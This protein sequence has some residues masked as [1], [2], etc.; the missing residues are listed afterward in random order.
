MVRARRAQRS[1]R[2]VVAAALVFASAV[3]V[4]AALA[5]GHLV[6]LSAVFAVVAAGCAVR[7]MHSEVVATR[8]SAARARADQARRFQSAWIQS[9]A[10]HQEFAAAAAERVRRHQAR[11]D[12]LDRELVTA[13][14]ARA[15]AEVVAA[16]GNRRSDDAQRRLESETRRADEAEARLRLESQR[17]KAAQ[18]RLAAVLDEVFGITLYDA[19]EGR[20]ANRRRTVINMREWES[21]LQA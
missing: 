14:R 20:P 7:I 8:A 21:R 15:D 3:L 17:V 18:E 12:V 1:V 16:L 5:G 4:A 2:L 19:D 11:V 10:S 13:R 9:Q 6:A